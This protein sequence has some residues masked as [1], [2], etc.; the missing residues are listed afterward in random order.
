MML[1]TKVCLVFSL[2]TCG[3][4][5]RNKI[6]IICKN[7]KEFVRIFSKNHYLLLGGGGGNSKVVQYTRSVAGH[8]TGDGL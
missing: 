8:Q 1:G 4:V 6:N 2:V 5:L 3:L 7:L